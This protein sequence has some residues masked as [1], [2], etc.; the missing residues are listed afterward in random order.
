MLEENM[1]PYLRNMDNEFI[2]RCKLISMGG[3]QIRKLEPTMPSC[4]LP[5]LIA[6]RKW[7]GGL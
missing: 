7:S 5:Q 4:S 3:M 6:C 2:Y 1:A